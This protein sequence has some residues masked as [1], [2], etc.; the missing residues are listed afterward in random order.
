MT[1]NDFNGL[2][3]QSAL[4]DWMTQGGFGPIDKLSI[5]RI[6]GGASNV[7]FRIEAGDKQ[8]A[9]R[10]PPKV[11]NDKTSDTILR[12]IKLLKALGKSNVRHARLVAECEDASV[13][14]VPFAMLEWV[15]GFTPMDPLPAPFDKPDVTLRTGMAYELIDALATIANADWQEMGLEGFGKPD[16][17]LERQVQRWTGQLERYRTRDIPFLDDVAA[18]LAANRPEMQRAAL[19][20]G[21]YQFINVMFAPTTPSRLAA[22][23]DWESATIGDPL[24]D[25]GHLL[26]GW[27]DPAVTQHYFSPYIDWTAFPPRA[28]LAARYAEKTGLSIENL[29]YYMAL[30]L[31]RLGIIM[32]GAYARHVSGAAEGDMYAELE[33]VVPGMIR[34][35]ARIIELT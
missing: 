27:R 25:L 17:F 18:W 28:E 26:S 32:E 16:G 34:E 19:M 9:L 10:R 33:Q 30:A 15:D 3:D 7:I 29:D 11:I 6:T 2:L 23:I 35:A 24:L 13:I 20:H 8:Y 22:V 4:H 14:G 12:E 21:D 1:V 5:E 31:F